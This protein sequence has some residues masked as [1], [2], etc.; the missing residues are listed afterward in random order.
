MRKLISFCLHGDKDKY[1]KGFRRNVTLSK[2]VYPEWEVVL[3]YDNTVPDHWIEKYKKAGVDLHN[4][5]GCWLHPTS[6]RFLACELPE[7]VGIIFGEADSEG[8]KREAEAVK[9]WEESGLGL[10]TM[11]D[12]PN[13]VNPMYPLFA[14]M[15]GVLPSKL[16][17]NMRQEILS[18]QGPIDPLDV[19][20]KWG[21]DQHFLRDVILP[22]FLFTK[23]ILLH[24]SYGGPSPDE[25][26]VK[27]FPSD[28]NAKNNF[29]GEIFDFVNGK[30]ERGPQWQ[31]L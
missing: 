23:S 12:H 2:K 3:F 9:E 24:T 11:R 15:W 8:S 27:D 18:Y 20:Y 4:V 21:T 28:R 25:S 26:L 14:G 10:H 6:Y 22:K 17:L 7:V 13:H 31:D 16:D 30:E 19:R 1:C 5:D 29:V